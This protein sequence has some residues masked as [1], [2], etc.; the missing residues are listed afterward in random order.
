MNFTNKYLDNLLI[1]A[2][3]ISLFGLKQFQLFD[4]LG[5][6]KTVQW[7]LVPIVLLCGSVDLVRNINKLCRN[8]FI[9]FQMVMLVMFLCKN[10]EYSMTSN[11]LFSIAVSA[12]IFTRHSFFCGR[13]SK[14]IINLI[15]FFSL[16]LIVQALI[17]CFLPELILA[18]SP[19]FSEEFVGKNIF[20]SASP[21][22]GSYKGLLRILGSST[23]D[24]VSFGPFNF[25]R[26]HSFLL[27]P[28]LSLAWFVLPGA[29][30]LSIGGIYFRIGL[31]IL[32]ASMITGSWSVYFL[33]PMG[34][35]TLIVLRCGGNARLNT[36][37]C[38]GATL[39]LL[40]TACLVLPYETEFETPLKYFT[41]TNPSLDT[42]NTK[43]NSNIIRLGMI[44]NAVKLC[45]ENPI[46]GTSKN[47]CAP[48][49]LFCFS[50][51]YGGLI[52]LI[53]AIL[54]FRKFFSLLS[55]R[56]RETS[57][58][59]FS[60]SI[61]YLLFYTSFIEATLFNDYGFSTAFGLVFTA[62]IYRLLL[63]ER[64][65]DLLLSNSWQKELRM[66]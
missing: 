58:N 15:F 54:F 42:G 24:L 49:G 37:L 20:F 11:L 16:L 28:S 23:N 29:L 48:M 66:W 25:S 43:A 17:I 57:K 65:S 40:A 8:P 63:G 27:E 34:I 31:I 56:L 18:I 3:A 51:L 36:F 35:L 13:L 12:S 60:R 7:A 5:I 50:A 14:T 1:V 6:R 59:G 52:G 41:T 21:F 45:L 26:P 4:L 38:L 55:I 64:S 53:C 19:P 61:P 30:A 62:L 2:I 9:I 47:Q 44:S 39:F 10:M 46:F 22:Q 32:L 33:F